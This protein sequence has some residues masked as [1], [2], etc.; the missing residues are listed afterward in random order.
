VTTQK[1]LTSFNIS[2]EMVILANMIKSN[3]V[4]RKLTKDL[5]PYHWRGKKHRTIFGILKKMSEKNLKFDFDTFESIAKEND[6]FGG[7]T[8]LQKISNLFEENLN[9]DYH[10]DILKKDSVKHHIKEHW[11]DKFV[12]SIEDPHSDIEDIIKTVEGIKDRIRENFT[13]GTLLFGKELKKNYLLDLNERR[14]KSI[15]VPIGIEGLDRWVTEGLAKKKT[16]I[17]SSRPGMGKTT[18]MANVALK[19]SKGVKDAQGNYLEEPKRVCL[20]PLETGHISYMDIM[21][22]I[23]IK[24]RL[25]AEQ[26]IESSV[27]PSSMVGMPLDRLVKY[28][29]QL[30]DEEF[31]LIKWALDQIF[32]NDNLVVVDDPF[33]SLE[34]LEGILEEGNF[35]ICIIDLWEKLSDIK[36]DAGRIAEKLNR[37]QQIAKSTNCHMAIVH[38]IRRS[39]DQKP[40]KIK[41]PTMEMLKNSGG[42]E[43]I[44]DLIV[45]MHRAK[46]YDP[47]LVEDVI[48]YIIAKQRRGPMNKTTFH[49]FH[50]NFGVIGG[51]RKN[52]TEITE[53]DDF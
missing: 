9:I 27:L 6:D 19:K 34:K 46:Y 35:D 33:L 49:D 42:Y 26:V 20:V 44:A 14:K 53:G 23:L 45:L 11:M 31:S 1:K 32:E 41:K 47:N 21:I 28:S 38:Q 25:D 17:W 8:Y 36:L 7:V 2:N 22:S 30:D 18:T 10:V 15:F 4:R 52:Y 13:A 40:G 50:Q 24:E 43:E 51:Y 39:P 37:T 29:D 5:K 48:E 12:D 3:K 16:S